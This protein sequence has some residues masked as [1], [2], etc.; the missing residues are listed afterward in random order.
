M[1]GVDEGDGDK[2]KREQGTEVFCR[3]VPG[4]VW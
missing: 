2:Y 1:G 3:V 4:W